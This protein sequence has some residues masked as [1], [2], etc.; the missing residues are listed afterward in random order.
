MKT[1]MQFYE[2]IGKLENSN[3]VESILKLLQ[4]SEKLSAVES[5][6]LKQ[7]ALIK[8]DLIINQMET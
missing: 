7:I 8:M 4:I 2:L 1:T 3:T 5:E 6:K